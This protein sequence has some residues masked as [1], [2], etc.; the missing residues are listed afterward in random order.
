MLS[1]GLLKRA[2][3]CCT[4]CCRLNVIAS[5]EPHAP[6]TLQRSL[7]QITRQRA[8]DE[9]RRTRRTMSQMWSDRKL[10]VQSQ[11]TDNTRETL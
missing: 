11:I 10:I 9:S 6:V 5:E 8:V 4:D 1:P 3:V 7:S 2:A